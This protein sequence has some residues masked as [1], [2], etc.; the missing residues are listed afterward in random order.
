MRSSVLTAVMRTMIF[1]LLGSTL[2]VAP[3]AN[4]ATASKHLTRHHKTF[5]SETDRNANAFWPE[6]ANAFVADQNGF[7]T[8]ERWPSGMQPDDWRQSVNGN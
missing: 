7:G 8:T 1:G 4:A 3:M 2:I 6:P 5:A